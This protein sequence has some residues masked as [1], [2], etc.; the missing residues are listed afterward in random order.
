MSC[1][2]PCTWWCCTIEPVWAPPRKLRTKSLSYVCFRF[3]LQDKSFVLFYLWYSSCFDVKCWFH[4]FPKRCSH[5]PMWIL[6]LLIYRVCHPTSIS[7]R[8]ASLQ[9][10]PIILP[11]RKINYQFFSTVFVSSVSKLPLFSRP[12]TLFLQGLR[13]INQVSFYWWEVSPFFSVNALIRWFSGRF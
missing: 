2:L 12:P 6:I 11:I 4:T 5:I 3:I 13:F 1:A 10:D 7:N 9:D 8:C